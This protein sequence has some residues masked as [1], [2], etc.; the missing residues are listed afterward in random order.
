[1]MKKIKNNLFALAAVTI[2]SVTMSFSVMKN[3]S[4]AGEKWF[5][6][7]DETGDGNISN[8]ENFALVN[9]NGSTA[10]PCITGNDI[11]CAIKA[12]PLIGDTEHPDM[13]TV[14]SSIYTRIE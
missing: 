7:T 3:A 9:E 1:M 10:P 4:L 8:P 6:Y 13:N 5:A 14:I 12:K 2:A 11:L